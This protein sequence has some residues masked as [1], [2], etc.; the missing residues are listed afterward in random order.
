MQTLLQY[1]R[2]SIISFFA[3]LALAF[4]LG[5]HTHGTLN[6]TVGFLLVATI[7]VLLEISLS[8]DNAVV[9]ANILERMTPIWQRRFLT[10]G[11]VIAVFGM[12][13]IF[14][15]LVVAI[16]AGIGPFAAVELAI[17]APQEYTEM[18]HGAYLPIAAF[19]GSFLMMV[20]LSY[21][22]DGD[23]TVDWIPPLERHLRK[24]SGFRGVNIAVVVGVLLCV[25]LAVPAAR[26]GV[27]LTSALCGV[28]TFLAVDMLGQVLDRP[29]TVNDVA[30]AGGLG[31]F[32][33]LEVLDA[34]FSFDGVIG[35]FSLTQNLFLIAI[36]LG[37]G[38]MFVRS[39]TI[40]LVEKRTLSKFQFLEHGAFYS[41]FALSFVMLMQIIVHVSEL[42]TGALCL[43]ILVLALLSSL[44]ARRV[45]T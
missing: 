5:W 6:G 42:V 20:A 15:V 7:L 19:G 28:L 2:W 16:A 10:W 31:T 37:V 39:L 8:F 25:N 38:A 43:G 33:Y 1:C 9:N 23:K 32:I 21:F 26:T 44:R 22:I 18:M 27:F 17:F 36:G 14:P 30:R 29:T 41:I 35:A 24:A 11:I 40:L 34:S 13:L 3:G 45:M 4:A 12:R